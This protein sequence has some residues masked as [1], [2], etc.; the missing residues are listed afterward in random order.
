MHTANNYVRTTGLGEPPEASPKA[1]S[2]GG[3]G[4]R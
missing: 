4:K 3:A 1:I 2:A